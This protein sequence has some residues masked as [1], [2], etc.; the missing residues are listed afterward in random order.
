MI[1]TSLFFR[2]LESEGLV[3]TFQARTGRDTDKH[4]VAVINRLRDARALMKLY[5]RSVKLKPLRPDLKEFS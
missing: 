1:N 5:R 3:H 4:I 2:E